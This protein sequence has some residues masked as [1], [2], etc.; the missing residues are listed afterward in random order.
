MVRCRRKG[1]DLLVLTSLYVPASAFTMSCVLTGFGLGG[2][3]GSAE[4]SDAVATRVM[5]EF[6]KC[7][8]G[9]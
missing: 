5:R 1:T 4:L 9:R 3:F 8:F 7:I 2:V 6:V